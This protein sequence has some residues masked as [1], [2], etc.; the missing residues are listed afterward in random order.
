M[1]R[2][3]DD[4]DDSTGSSENT[5]VELGRRRLMTTLEVTMTIRAM[6]GD[7]GVDN[8][9]EGCSISNGSNVQRYELGSDVDTYFF[10]CVQSCL[11]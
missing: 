6:M 7:S 4:D 2:R 5:P 8:D 3:R 9:D 1:E 10:V 11:G